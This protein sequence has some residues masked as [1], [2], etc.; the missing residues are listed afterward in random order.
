VEVLIDN[1]IDQLRRR[2]NACLWATGEH[3][4]YPLWHRLVKNVYTK[5]KFIVKED[6]SFRLSLVSGR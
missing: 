6:I 5:F 1:V 2:L 3:F 4:E